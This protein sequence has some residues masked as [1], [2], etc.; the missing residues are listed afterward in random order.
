MGSSRCFD[1]LVSVRNWEDHHRR[2]AREIRPS[3]VH[4]SYECEQGA[5]RFL[6]GSYVAILLLFSAMA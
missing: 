1:H 2:L 4:Y 6:S 5:H 3:A